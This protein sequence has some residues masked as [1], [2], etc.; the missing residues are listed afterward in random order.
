M[1]A[2]TKLLYDHSVCSKCYYAFSNRRQAAFLIDRV[3]WTFPNIALGLG[4]GYWLGSL[5]TPSKEIE[6]TANIL[7]WPFF[8]LF[9]LKDGFNGYSPG[10]ALCGVQ[11]IDRVTRKPIGFAASFKRNLPLLIPIVPL[12][13]AFQLVKGKRI[14]DGWANSM[15]IW[16][17]YECSHVFGTHGFCEVCQYDLQGNT[18]G[19]CSECGTPVSESN[20]KHFALTQE[21]AAISD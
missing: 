2:N 19:T 4:L 17:R 8:L 9:F 5:G 12:V 11:T 13:V 10:K 16:K 1:G 7:S 18:S 6:I 14:G 20:K 15:V 21:I 3:L